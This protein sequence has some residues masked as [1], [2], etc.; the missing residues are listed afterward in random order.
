MSLRIAMVSDHASPLAAA[1]GVDS[2]GQNV[3]VAQLARHL[4]RGGHQVDVYTRRDEPSQPETLTCPDGYRVIHVP[5]GPARSIP[6]EDLLP[7]MDGFS[8]Y[9]LARLSREPADLIHANFFMSALV[10][11]RMKQALG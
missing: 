11:M 5:A 7:Y 9:M 10:A 2:G 3:Y 4:V 1:G 8:R 6:K